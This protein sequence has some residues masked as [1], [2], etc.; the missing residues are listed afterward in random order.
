MIL[1]AIPSYLPPDSHE[2]LTQIFFESYN[3]ANLLIV[4]RALVQLY[5]CASMS[6]VTV[7]V[8]LHATEVAVI[9]EAHIHPPSLVR[10]SIGEAECDQ[11]LVEI[12]LEANPELPA[13]LSVPSG[14]S[15][16][17]SSSQ[18][19]EGE[20]LYNA[21]L[22][23]VNIMKDGEYIRFQV[24]KSSQVAQAISNRDD[25]AAIDGDGLGNDGEEEEEG[26]TDVAKALASGKVGQMLASGQS[27]NVTVVDGDKLE[28]QNPYSSSLP[29]IT[30]GLERNRY[31]EPLFNPSLLSRCTRLGAASASHKA[32]SPSLPEVIAS[33]V[34]TL[35]EVEKRGIVWESVVFTGGLARVK[36]MRTSPFLS[37]FDVR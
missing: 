37:V 30:I 26:I 6:G 22:R 19:L 2:R 9:Y 25:G 21:V 28:I 15:E 23:L 34:R 35:P 29:A 1:L 33:A 12:L 24:D 36:G 14:E 3:I 17:S 10:C 11:Y 31:A 5:S 20:A 32:S 7:D 16:G 8:G 4:E 13:Q 27:A 18:P